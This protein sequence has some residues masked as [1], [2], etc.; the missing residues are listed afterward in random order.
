M[1]GIIEWFFLLC[2]HIIFLL[3]ARTKSVRFRVSLSVKMKVSEMNY[4]YTYI[5]RHLR[6][7]GKEEKRRR[8]IRDEAN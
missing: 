3:T 6:S 5:A 1:K 8:R 7:I 2:F 4:N